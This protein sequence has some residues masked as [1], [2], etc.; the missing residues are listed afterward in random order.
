MAVNCF[1]QTRWLLESTDGRWKTFY[2]I[3]ITGLR[4]GEKIYEELL[5]DGENT[6]AT[7][8]EKIMIAKTKTF[9][10]NE[11]EEKIL[12]LCAI[13][14]NTQNIEIVSLIKDILPE[15][16]SNNSKYGV[17]DSKNKLS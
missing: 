12:D 14:S 7:Y 17:L 3:K 8:N 10:I 6:K 15:Y 11:I 2:Q 13:T 9:N 5:A 16:I 4:P 1:T